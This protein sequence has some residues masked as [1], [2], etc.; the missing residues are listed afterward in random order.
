MG[1]LTGQSARVHPVVAHVVEREPQVA[2]G[3]R[4]RIWTLG[5]A[6]PGPVLRGR[7]GDLLENTLVK[8]GT[9]GHRLPA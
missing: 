3:V 8:E 6:A 2:P 5:P 9:L 1:L 7:V 4:Q